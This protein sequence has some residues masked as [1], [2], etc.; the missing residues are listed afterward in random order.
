MS[1]E[2]YEDD[3][4]SYTNM[5]VEGM[6]WYRP[7]TPGDEGKKPDLNPKEA[8][9][10]IWGTLKAALLIAGIYAVVF[11]LFILFCDNVWFK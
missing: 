11:F 3:G 4:K 6:P 2:K 1:K 8:R 7:K 10:V 9:Q 5:N